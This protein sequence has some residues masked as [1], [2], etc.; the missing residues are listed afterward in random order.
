M[1]LVGRAAQET[2]LL[3]AELL[4]IFA[5][6]KG[7]V[8]T[9][10]RRSTV[11]ILVPSGS[12]A[13]RGLSTPLQ[14]IQC[15]HS[16]SPTVFKQDYAFANPSPSRFQERL[17]T[18]VH[19]STSTCLQFASGACELRWINYDGIESTTEIDTVS[20]LIALASMALC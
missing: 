17:C 8:W 20:T 16:V 18:D 12:T 6:W 5:A 9:I 15:P 11:L 14:L 2:L 10:G 13:A 7:L 1:T 19:A 4:V 3:H